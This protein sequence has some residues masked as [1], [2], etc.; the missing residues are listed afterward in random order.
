MMNR[1]VLAVALVTTSFATPSVA[2]AKE[3]T[4]AYVTPG[5]DVPFWRDLAGGIHKEAEKLG[6]KVIDSDSRNSA[7][8]QLKNVQDLI[9]AGVDAI[10][11]SPTDSGSAHRSLNWQRRPRS[12]W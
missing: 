10:I 5:L 12:P 8:T 7:A 6:V 4:M 3:Y 9:T 1:L 2:T 11:I